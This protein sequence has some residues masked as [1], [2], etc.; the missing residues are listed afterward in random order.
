MEEFPSG[1]LEKAVARHGATVLVRYEAAALDRQMAL[2]S[3]DW[4]FL[5]GRMEEFCRRY[6]ALLVSQPEALRAVLEAAVRAMTC[7]RRS[8]R[9]RAALV[10]L[11]MVARALEQGLSLQLARPQWLTILQAAEQ[12]LGDFPADLIDAPIVDP[13]LRNLLRQGRLI[14]ST[15]AE[16]PAEEGW[17]QVLEKSGLLALA[18]ARKKVQLAPRYDG[19]FDGLAGAEAAARL[20]QPLDAGSLARLEEQ[21]AALQS[22]LEARERGATDVFLELFTLRH[23][24]ERLFDV[25]GWLQALEQALRLRSPVGARLLGLAARWLEEAG[26]RRLLFELSSG[27]RRICDLVLEVDPAGRVALDMVQRAA[28]RLEAEASEAIRDEAQ[29]QLW[30]LGAEITGRLMQLWPAERPGLVKLALQ[31]RTGPLGGT[32]FSGRDLAWWLELAT[33]YPSQAEA[34]LL[35]P[36]AGLLLEK[37]DLQETATEKGRLPAALARLLAADWPQRLGLAVRSILRLAPLPAFTLGGESLRD[38]AG[39]LQARGGYLRHLGRKLLELAPERALELLKNL[40]QSW[41]DGRPEPLFDW[42]EPEELAGFEEPAEQRLQKDFRQVIE[43]LRR[44]L[45]AR[46]DWVFLQRAGEEF[47]LPDTIIK[48][49]GF[50]G[51][52]RE[53]PARLALLFA[54]QRKISRGMAGLHHQPQGFEQLLQ[55]SRRLAEERRRIAGEMRLAADNPLACLGLFARELELSGRAE[56]VAAELVRQFGKDPELFAP[57]CRQLLEHAVLSQQLSPQAAEMLTEGAAEATGQE[58]SRRFVEILEEEVSWWREALA[59]H[60]VKSARGGAPCPP[61]QGRGVL[62]QEELLELA[63]RRLMEQEEFLP[64]LKTLTCGLR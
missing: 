43:G 56:A 15:L 57:L 24:L 28:A 48:V 62:G 40:L 2:A 47:E 45:G 35:R 58:F 5:L 41:Q 42:L 23:R 34:L 44:V 63:L 10:L 51:L 25:H 8:A 29:D 37:F 20:L 26:D 59:S 4:H 32:P 19:R 50:A 64:R 33:A 16:R 46:E 1:P 3:P 52:D 54:L 53:V 13:A 39:K 31:L 17:L 6:P 38:L 22:A 49:A 21:I 36:L 18:F 27:L 11:E 30:Y 7:G 14:I 9:L 61:G 55:A 12:A 60:V